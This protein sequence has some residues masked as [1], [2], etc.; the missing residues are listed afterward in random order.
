MR[1]KKIADPITCLEITIL[2]ALLENHF[3]IMPFDD[4]F[5]G[6]ASQL[7]AISRGLTVI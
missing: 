3:N 4:D 7:M 6:A 1:D 2:S 5:I